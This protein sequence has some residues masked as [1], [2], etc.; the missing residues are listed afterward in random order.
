[1]ITTIVGL[2]NPGVEYDGTRHNIGREVVEGFEGLNECAGWKED[3]EV[4]AHVT[5]R[6]V[7]KKKVRLVLPNT[8]M[9]RSG[10]T[11]KKLGFNEKN[12]SDLVVVQ[13]DIDLPFGKIRISYERGD[14]GHNGLKSIM[15]N[16][17]SN[18]FARVRV[19]V[20]PVTSEGEIKK[21]SG[22]KEVRDYVLTSFSDGE[23]KSLREILKKSREALEVLVLE[24]HVKAM[25]QFN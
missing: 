12:L 19:G 21:V 15:S 22:E 11:L 17:G 8:Y 25:N 6:L 9:N 13:D 10:T 24:G 1:M 3:R 16:L 2:G 23:K 14:G 7:G 20:A 18:S 5:Q 4:N